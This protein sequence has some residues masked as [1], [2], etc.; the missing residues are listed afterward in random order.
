[1]G[2]GCGTHSQSAKTF[3][4]SPPGVPEA[5]ESVGAQRK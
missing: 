1:M 5:Q 2:M 4:V 3:A